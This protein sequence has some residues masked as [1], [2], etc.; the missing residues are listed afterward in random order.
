MNE[1]TLVQQKLISK[2]NKDGVADVLKPF[3]KDVI[4]YKTFVSDIM[5]LEDPI[6]VEN[7]KIGDKLSLKIGARFG[8]ENYIGLYDSSDELVGGIAEY[9]SEILA[10][11]LR[12]GKELY[13][14]VD[15]KRFEYTKRLTIKSKIMHKIAIT[16][17]MREI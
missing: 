9:E 7:V 11:L 15:D 13:A 1:L 16:I 4:I 17:Y 3:V 6:P 8:N 2:I 10:N 12:A 14:I 5:F